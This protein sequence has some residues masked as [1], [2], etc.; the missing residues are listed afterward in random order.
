MITVP[1]EG[2]WR[3]T[4]DNPFNGLPENAFSRT[5]MHLTFTE[6]YRPLI[7][8]D[9]LQGQDN[10]IFVQ[11][12]VISVHNSGVRIGDVD[13]QACLDSPLLARRNPV[14]CSGVAYHQ[15][16]EACL[17][18]LKDIITIEQW[19]DIVEP[20][21]RDMVIRAHESWVARLATA[22]I[23]IQS[24]AEHHQTLLGSVCL[25]PKGSC[26]KCLCMTTFLGLYEHRLDRDSNNPRTELL[27]V[28]IF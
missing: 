19:D 18:R 24:S 9:M 2:S 21:R 27:N 22:L 5:S 12:S 17:D 10:Q 13:V 6:Y 3:L 16:W 1:E 23:L 26:W 28:T 25:F 7:Q 15:H 14:S 4:S 8:S 20:P 11:E